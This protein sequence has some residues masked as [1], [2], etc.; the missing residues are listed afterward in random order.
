MGTRNH[1]NNVALIDRLE[2]KYSKKLAK[3]Q[4]RQV[5]IRDSISS[6]HGMRI[7]RNQY[8]DYEVIGS[9]A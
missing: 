3:L 4:K 8:L 2:E 1:Q 5:S 6:T 9:I 7:T